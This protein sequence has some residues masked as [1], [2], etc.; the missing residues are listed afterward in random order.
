[1]Q[2]KSLSQT[3]VAANMIHDDATQGCSQS[4]LM[5]QVQ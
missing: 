5:T 3:T 1:M 4:K 2:H